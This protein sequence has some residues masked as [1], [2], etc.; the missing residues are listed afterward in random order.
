VWGGIS[1]RTK[2]HQQIFQKLIIMKNALLEL[3]VDFIGG[4]DPLTAEEQKQLSEYFQ[5]K[6]LD[7]KVVQR[8]KVVVRKRKLVA[9]L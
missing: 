1:I 9:V 6:K 5:Q 8:K 4:Q 7:R 2:T 3:D